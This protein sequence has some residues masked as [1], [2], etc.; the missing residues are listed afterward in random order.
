V[1]AYQT[2]NTFLV[3]F[4]TQLNFTRWVKYTDGNFNVN[5]RSLLYNPDQDLVVMLAENDKN[6]Y[7]RSQIYPKGQFYADSQQ[8]NILIMCHNGRE[9]VLKWTNLIGDPVQN[10][11]LAAAT[12]YQG[13]FLIH[14]KC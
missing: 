5:P 8:T 2:N 3:N 11:T 10:D 7:Y 4:D 6:T 1:I 12:I 13:I 14:I 9:G